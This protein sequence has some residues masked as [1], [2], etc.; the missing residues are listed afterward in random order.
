MD[1]DERY[2]S[3]DEYDE[4][5]ALSYDDEDQE[6]FQAI[7][8][9]LT[10]TASSSTLLARNVNPFPRHSSER[11]TGSFNS[12]SSMNDLPP[13]HRN[14]L[15]SASSQV[16]ATPVPPAPTSSQGGLDTIHSFRAS[17]PTQS[18]A[19]TPHASPTITQTTPRMSNSS[20]V[21]PKEPEP[22]IPIVNKNHRRVRSYTHEHST[23]DTQPQLQPELQKQIASISY[24][25]NHTVDRY[26]IFHEN[27]YEN[28]DQHYRWSYVDGCDSSSLSDDVNTPG[29]IKSLKRKQKRKKSKDE[30]AS[31][32]RLLILLGVAFSLVFIAH[33]NYVSNENYDE[34][35]QLKN[36]TH[37]GSSSDPW[38][39]ENSTQKDTFQDDIYHSPSAMSM[40]RDAIDDL[41]QKSSI[42][43]VYNGAVSADDSRCS[44]MGMKIMRDQNGNAMDAAVTTA[45]CLGL[46][47]P[48]SSGIGGGGFIL[49]HSQPRKTPL[50]ETRPQTPFEDHRL[51]KDD[52]LLDSQGK[53]MEVIDCR[54]T[55]PSKA[56]YDMFES[57]TKGDSTIGPLAIA[58]PGELRG[59]ELAHMRYGSLSWEKILAPVIE[60]AE[61]GVIVSEILAKE[62]HDN[63]EFIFMYEALRNALTRN[64][65]GNMNDYLVA[66]DVMKRPLYTATLKNIAEN[67]ADYIYNRVT[68]SNI[69]YQI[70]NFGGIITSEDIQNYKPI[71]RDAIVARVD[72]MTIASVP[73]PSSGGAVI[74]GALRFLSGY[75]NPYATFANTLSVH[76]FVEALKHVFAIRMS[77][78]DPAFYSNVTATAVKDL[79]S[80]PFMEEL[81]QSALDDNILPLNEYGGKWALISVADDQGKGK[82]AHEGDRRRNLRNKRLE[83]EERIQKQSSS[84]RRR[85]M[86]FN[87]LEDHGT[88]HLNVVDKDRNAVS[89]TTSVNYYFGSTYACPSTGI[90]FNNVMDDF[91]TPGRTN[92]YGL[93]PA[94]S[95]YIAPGKR[96]LSSM[97]PTMIFDS[98]GTSN[99]LGN[100]MLVVGASGGPKIISAV[101]QIILNHLYRGLPLFEAVVQARVHNQLLYHGSSGTSYENS[102]LLD[103]HMI[104]TLNQTRNAL[105]K[106]HHK[107]YPIDYTGTCQAISVDVDTN[108]L[109]ATSDPRK[110]GKSSGY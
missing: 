80:G 4:D 98:S 81:R 83:N 93:H 24:Q 17:T 53:R 89:I 44:E 95:N 86:G 48:A 76:R 1:P 8:Q 56:T 84:R 10:I 110:N 23:E 74:V 5:D 67:G 18:N 39:Q 68:A 34:Y 33:H 108:E 103:G 32:G 104:E 35:G 38:L 92:T 88:S 19:S 12:Y 21:R 6:E 82:D 29:S 105:R 106:R 49:V 55:A 91:S 15:P 66:G 59:L 75:S 97:S 26:S 13:R 73:P 47:N 45:F 25:Q 51:K 54:E 109:T 107:L 27:G 101:L 22:P 100:L 3:D 14:R 52:D 62:I 43:G 60:L 71:L 57:I 46:V 94:E 70:Q 99:E 90:I 37:T 42:S 58:V 36:T 77:L 65:T 28:E 11:S 78:S 50:N 69:A 79:T 61:K 2:Y 41:R 87:Y 9:H 72:G 31:L 85:T 64:N 96:P 7:D 30:K 20:G 63:K 16:S 40:D 102:T